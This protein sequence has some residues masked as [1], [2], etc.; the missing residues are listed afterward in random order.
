MDGMGQFKSDLIIRVL[1]VTICRIADKGQPC[2]EYKIMEVLIVH[3]KVARDHNGVKYV[4]LKSLNFRVRRYPGVMRVIRTPHFYT[5][6]PIPSQYSF[7]L[8]N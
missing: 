1:K 4:L 6:P 5:R 7:F 3:K 8:F 2:D